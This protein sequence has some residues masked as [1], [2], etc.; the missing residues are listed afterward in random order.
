[1]EKKGIDPAGTPDG[2][3]GISVPIDPGIHDGFYAG[4]FM[5]IPG[6]IRR[7]WIV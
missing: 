4:L 1:M 2:S 5:V 7:C 3:S 6:N